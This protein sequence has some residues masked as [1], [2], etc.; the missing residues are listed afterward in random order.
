M[1]SLLQTLPQEK[2][3]EFWNAKIRTNLKMVHRFF[4]TGRGDHPTI[5]RLA[6][7][8]A[9]IEM[10]DARVSRASIMLRGR[11]IVLRASPERGHGTPAKAQIET[12]GLCRCQECGETFYPGQEKEKSSHKRTCAHFLA[13]EVMES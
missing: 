2:E 11:K 4:S 5:G 7:I 3:T 10:H 12:I 1:K 6:D 9:N 8:F 13:L